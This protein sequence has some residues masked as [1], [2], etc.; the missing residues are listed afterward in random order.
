MNGVW[1]QYRED[2]CLPQVLR[3]S[4]QFVWISESGEHALIMQTNEEHEAKQIGELKEGQLHLLQPKGVFCLDGDTR[5]HI[6]QTFNA[7][8]QPSM[9]AV[10]QL[11][12][13]P[14]TH[15]FELP[16]YRLSGYFS[17]ET[18]VIIGYEQHD[19]AVISEETP[20]NTGIW[21]SDRPD[22]PKT[23]RLYLVPI[24]PFYKQESQQKETITDVHYHLNH[25]VQ[26]ILQDDVELEK[27]TPF[28]TLMPLVV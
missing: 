8:E 7:F 23:E 24:R 1:Y 12:D 3:Q 18:G 19:Y 17:S 16:Y 25:D 20:F 10:V 9:I 13:K 22:A 6:L 5:T 27:N 2:D 21:L 14:D 11:E 4:G 28:F 15:Q 26:R